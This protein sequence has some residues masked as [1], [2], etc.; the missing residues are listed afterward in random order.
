LAVLAPTNTFLALAFGASLA[1]TASAQFQRFQEPIVGFPEVE[2]SALPSI[3]LL[4]CDGPTP[5]IRDI[6]DFCLLDEHRLAILR[7]DQSLL[8]VTDRGALLREFHLPSFRIPWGPLR[9]QIEHFD[10]LAKTGP[11]RV[12]LTPGYA[13]DDSVFRPTGM[14]EL[15]LATGA[16]RIP[17]FLPPA[18][19]EISI[20]GGP[21]GELAVLVHSDSDTSKLVVLD[22]DG[23]FDWSRGTRLCASHEMCFTPTGRIALLDRGQDGVQLIRWRGW[24]STYTRLGLESGERGGAYKFQC[25]PTGEFLFLC[26]NRTGSTLVRTDEDFE[27]RGEIEPRHSEGTPINVRVR[28]SPAGRIWAS[29]WHSLSRLGQDGLA[30][31]TLGVS[32]E[33]HRL[34]GASHVAVDREDRIFAVAERDDAV[35]EFDRTGKRVRVTPRPS[36]TPPTRSRDEVPKGYEALFGRGGPARC[37]DR[38][39]EWDWSRLRLL[40]PSGVALFETA[41]GAGCVVA[42]PSADGAVVL[43]RRAR[44]GTSGEAVLLDVQAEERA[45]WPLPEVSGC[46]GRADLDARCLVL[47]LS[48]RV[49]AWRADGSRWFQ[50]GIPYSCSYMGCG[51]MPS[52]CWMVHLTRD[53]RELWLWRGPEATTIERYALP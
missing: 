7:S 27:L 16:M 9:V 8:V 45:R 35:H 24:W 13:W 51:M 32:P 14:L 50:A 4:A 37:G 6:R 31:I 17:A 15:D 40:D 36:G 42:G 18:S 23:T 25:T 28:V 26:S 1:G 33:E 19:R 34:T 11:D 20:A 22:A 39:W 44:E 21:G 38:I 52:V 3:D 29:D 10:Q 5:E 43:L 46:S 30:E 48:D 41:L 2:L 47:A 49:L 12:I 53:G